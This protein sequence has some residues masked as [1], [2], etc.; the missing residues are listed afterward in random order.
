MVLP[1]SSEVQDG[2]PKQEI[3]AK[4]IG[5]KKDKEAEKLIEKEKEYSKEEM[6]VSKDEKRGG[7]PEYVIRHA[8]DREL[9]AEQVAEAQTYAEGL[10]YPIGATIFGRNNEDIFCTTTQTVER[11][12]SIVT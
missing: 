2:A 8:I 10:G 11:F 7:P 6:C 4:N 12:I 3:I 1:K 5:G 9:S